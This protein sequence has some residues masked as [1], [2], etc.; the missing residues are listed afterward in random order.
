MTELGQPINEFRLTARLVNKDTIRYTPAGQ[1]VLECQLD[2]SGTV[3][4]AGTERK[5]QIQ[6]LAIA[7]GQEVNILDQMEI[8]QLRNFQGF[9]AHRSA[10][11]KALVFHITHISI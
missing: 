9:M 6:I 4:E 1:A 8:G 7:I 3:F 5:V 10:R 11:Q 2:Y